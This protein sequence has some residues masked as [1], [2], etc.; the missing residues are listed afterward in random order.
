V[1]V[2]AAAGVLVPFLWPRLLRDTMRRLPRF[3]RV[4]DA[5]VPTRSGIG[6]IAAA[7]FVMW[8][9]HG[10]VFWVFCTAFAPL[11]YHAIPASAG[12]FC[13]A[14]VAGL[15]AIIAPGGIGVREEILG[16]ALERILP[17]GPVHV[18]AVS[19]RL[20]TMAAEIVVLAVALALRVR[21]RK[22]PS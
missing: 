9:A 15:A 12:S 13:L 16:H 21:S 7:F 11:P 8:L 18:L 4:S 3:L 6:R 2:V 17:E 1:C 5:V 14:Y 19:A 22:S 20:W 10:I